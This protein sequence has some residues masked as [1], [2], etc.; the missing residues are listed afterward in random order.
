MKKEI[1]LKPCP[2]CGSQAGI[3]KS[4]DA[5]PRFIAICGNRV[6]PE[7]PSVEAE[8]LEGAILLWNSRPIEDDLNE[9][10]G[11]FKKYSASL[12]QE[13]K[14]LREALEFY[15]YDEDGGD[16]AREALKGGEK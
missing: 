9:Q 14:T 7:Q 8:S 3:L 10:I 16:I 1:K 4:D 5:F 15:T 6:C 2:F 12:E 11:R 13:V